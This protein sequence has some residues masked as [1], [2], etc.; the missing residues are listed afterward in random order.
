MW[1]FIMKSYV[2]CLCILAITVLIP[3]QGDLSAETRPKCLFVGS[4]HR[5]YEWQDG[6]EK[7]IRATL[8]GKC[9]VQQWDLNTKRIPES[10][11]KQKA[12]EAKGLIEYWK[13]DIVIVSDDNASKY[14]VKPYY[15]DA[16]LPFVFCGVN[17]T[18][19][20]Y[21][22]PYSNVTGMTEVA[23]IL[24]MVK[25][26]RRILPKAKNAVCLGANRI[27]EIKYCQRYVQS[28]KKSGITMKTKALS[29]IDDFEK[30]YI[31]AQ[32]FDF[33]IFSNHVGI[34]DW[35]E[36]R[37]KKI[38]R[39]H[40]KKLTL[41]HN[42]WDLPYIMLAF[43]HFAEEQG[44]YAANVALKILEGAKPADFPIIANRK[45]SIYVNQPLLEKA[46][47]KLPGD[48]LRKA[49]KVK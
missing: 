5:G 39:R 28:F 35:D 33:I 8:K 13:P 19:R 46:G 43:T 3:L 29:N 2:S 4:Y 47:I 15:K 23:P 6:I 38:V 27:S 45:W 20:E 30:E 12:L 17:W 18:A 14:L 32:K 7:G 25:Q 41:G 34:N 16:K 26:V 10:E 11:F 21:G 48:L 36:S 44:E 9:D 49:E 1:G 31:A 40:S 22:Y 42:R 37:A 24:T